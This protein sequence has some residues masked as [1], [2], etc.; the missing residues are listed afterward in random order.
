MVPDSGF[1]VEHSSGSVYQP[2]GSVGLVQVS[3]RDFNVL[4]AFAYRNPAVEDY[5]VD[6]L[7]VRGVR[8]VEQA[9]ADVETALAFIPRQDNPT[10]LA[11][12]PR[13]LRWFEDPYGRHTLAALVHDELITTAPNTG[14]LHSD[15][16]ADRLFREMLATSGVPPLKRWVMWAG[17][18]LRTRWKAGGY[19]RASIVLWVAISLVG[20]PCA[21]WSA[22]ALASSLPM[23]TVWPTTSP[24]LS[25]VLALLLAFLAAG[26]W[27]RQ[28]GAG[29]V[30]AG[31]ALFIVPAAAAAGLGWCLY[32][33]LEGACSA[34]R[35]LGFTS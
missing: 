21:A 19:R 1:W 6:K 17:V 13:F 31:V 3:E 5:L 26:L 24:G 27:G 23:P 7:T 22:V 30:A 15:T 16:L 10:D 12:I 4:N 20:I 33:V 9:R 18:A 32:R 8:T 28:Y 11:T 34:P 14:A 29:L 25:L 2:P 35:R